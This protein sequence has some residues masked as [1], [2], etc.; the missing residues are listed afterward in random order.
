MYAMAVLTFGFIQFIFWAKGDLARHAHERAPAMVL[1][2]AAALQAVLVV[3]VA[4]A[5]AAAAVVVA[6]VVVA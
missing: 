2:A 6:A 5:V 1:A 3:V 4:A